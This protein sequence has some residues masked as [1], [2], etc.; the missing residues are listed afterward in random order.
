[1]KVEYVLIP[2][3]VRVRKYKVDEEALKKLLK[4]H[5]CYS[6]RK[7]SE[8]MG[9]SI[10]TVEHWFRSDKYFCIPEPDQWYKLKKILNIDFDYLDKSIVSF[11][12]RLGT[13][14]KA[15]RTYL[16]TGLS[17][18]LLTSCVESILVKA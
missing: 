11:V 10:T 12:E 8:L 17:P 7:I 18:C 13:F 3:T 4:N 5:K 6:N 16:T 9:E 1:M 14:E 2:Q 15:E